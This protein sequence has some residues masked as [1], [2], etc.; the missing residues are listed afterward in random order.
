MRIS[1][2][3][4]GVENNDALQERVRRRAAFALS[5]FGDVVQDV[6]VLLE[7]VNGPRGGVD[8][9]CRFLVSLRRGDSPVICETIH[10]D[11]NAAIDIS[12]DRVGRTVARA[13]ERHHRSRTGAD[14]PR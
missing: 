8:Q 2:R 6:D 4:K 1:I 12:G 13:M 3:A 9:R 11:I 5:R 7:D 14:K 10:A